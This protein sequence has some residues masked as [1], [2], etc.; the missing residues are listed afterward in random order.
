MT[1]ANPEE[2]FTDV[3]RNPIMTLLFLVGVFYMLSFSGYT[4][5]HFATYQLRML[6]TS[7]GNALI[8][9]LLATLVIS[10]PTT[11]NS[12]FKRVG[13]SQR[14]SYTL[15]MI[16]IILLFFFTPRMAR[17]T[18]VTAYSGGVKDT[19]VSTFLTPVTTIV[20]KKKTPVYFTD[21]V[22]S[23]SSGKWPLTMLSP[24]PPHTTYFGDSKGLGN[25]DKKKKPQQ[26]FESSTGILEE[27]NKKKQKFGQI[28][29]LN[30][31]NEMVV[32]Q[33]FET[34]SI[35]NG[36]NDTTAIGSSGFD[37]GNVDESGADIDDVNIDSVN[38]EMFQNVFKQTFVGAQPFE[39]K[40]VRNKYGGLSIA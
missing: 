23:E 34:I 39:T 11:W 5:A 4:V 6:L 14:V 10:W 27:A 9:M 12:M 20:P 1:F 25:S 3:L 24:I 15:A 28:L 30:K 29:K 13:I 37:F 17:V 31:N 40:V 26:T 32:V 33:P 7:I 16:V 38:T 22:K 19:T 2:F 18:S 35:G 36:P 8:T 21:V